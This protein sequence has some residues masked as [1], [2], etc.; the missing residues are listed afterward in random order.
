M[1]VL[2][3]L[4]G[5]TPQRNMSDAEVPFAES[6]KRAGGKVQTD[7]IPGNE[8]MISVTAIDFTDV[9]IGDADL[10]PLAKFPHLKTVV[11][12]G[13]KVTDAGLAAFKDCEHLE[14]VDLS[15]SLVSGSGLHDLRASR[16]RD[17]N[18]SNSK[19]NDARTAE[20]TEIGYS[21]RFLYLA[22]TEI[23]DEGMERLKKLRTLDGID[24]SRTRIS[25]SGLR[26]LPP[27]LKQLNLS[28]TPVLSTSLTHLERLTSL[29]RLNLSETSVTDDAIPYI[30]AM[31]E[32]QFLKAG[33]R[34]FVYLNL[35]KTA[36]SD[37]LIATLKKA[38]PG[39]E[40][41]L[42]EPAPD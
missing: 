9:P 29:E 34:K 23:T 41:D 11:L 13:T 16:I 27:A 12:R 36:V 20:L 6:L 32:A 25:G 14:T 7:L 3:L 33:R 5:C 2:S 31:I 37:K 38:A 35:H 22:G 10:P 1:L 28:G 40:V 21:F 15:H 39:L 24:L 4:V 19:F 17:L 18:L 26:Y 42:S 8:F 30:Q